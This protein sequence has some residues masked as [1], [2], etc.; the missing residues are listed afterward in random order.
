MGGKEALEELGK[1][2]SDEF[3]EENYIIIILT[4][5]TVGNM[6]YT[7]EKTEEN[8]K[9]VLKAECVYPAKTADIIGAYITPVEIRGRY[10]G[11]EISVERTYSRE[12]SRA[13]G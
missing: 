9:T 2:I 1:K 8:G 12:E 3:F 10:N 11:E 4:G 5:E 13:A 6:K 7:V